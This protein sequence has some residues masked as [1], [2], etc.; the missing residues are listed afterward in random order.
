MTPHNYPKKSHPKNYGKLFIV[1]SKKWIRA[2]N[3]GKNTTI[4]HYDTIAKQISN[5]ELIIPNKL[6][7]LPS[8]YLT[9]QEKN[10]LK[11]IQ[12]HFWQFGKLLPDKMD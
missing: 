4:V 8:L 6:L 5:M 11:C 1:I 12:R 3:E 9:H 7:W 10:K 2:N